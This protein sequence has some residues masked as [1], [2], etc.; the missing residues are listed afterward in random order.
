MATLA[1]RIGSALTLLIGLSVCQAGAQQRPAVQQPDSSH[2]A[3]ARDLVRSLPDWPAWTEFVSVGPAEPSKYGSNASPDRLPHVA[4]TGFDP[5]SHRVIEAV[6]DLST[7]QVALTTVDRI[8]MTTGADFTRCD[9]AVKADPR[10]QA[11]VARRGFTDPDALI[12]DGWASGIVNDGSGRRLARG[13]TYALTD[14]IN[15][16]DRPL[17]GIICTVDLD[18]RTVIDVVDHGVRPMA[19]VNETFERLRF[20]REPLVPLTIRHDQQPFSI[21]GQRVEWQDW[22]FAYLVHPRE[23]VVLYDV[24]RRIDGEERSVAWRIGLSEMVVPYGDTS[25]AWVWRNAFDVGEYGV[26][27][28]SWSLVRGADVPEEAVLL[29][30][31]AIDR[32]GGVSVVSDV[33]GIYE[34]D[35]GMYVRHRD[36]ATQQA[37]AIRGRELVVTHTAT[38]GN[39][40][41]AISYIF[42]LDGAIRVEAR[43]SG[44]LLVKGAGQ[45]AEM[46][47]APNL[48]APF[49]QHF[50]N[51]RLDLDVDGTANSVHELDAW[52]PPAGSSENPRGNAIML[53]DFEYLHESEARSE[54]NARASR[55][56]A[57]ANTERLGVNGKPT[58][59]MLMPGGN[60]FPYLDSMALPRRRARFIDHHFWATVYRNDELYAA[61]PYPNQS[62]GGEGLP[63]YIADNA[64]LHGRDVVVWYTM[65]ITHI[66]RPEDWP[67]MP[68]HVVGFTLMPMNISTAQR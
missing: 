26:G 2:I 21:S 64:P 5:A 17:E 63:H 27:V 49:H 33:V 67:I 11:A 16:Y 45:D 8:P 38:V 32:S 6:V 22:S 10:W 62:G 41:Y 68:A 48:E 23:G 54:V 42:G 9:S 24:R 19:P 51:F 28:C 3:A 4:L 20:T 46:P 66:T 65:G 30:V 34:R 13:I 52:S 60:A 29:P 50:F 55:S 37:I 1:E 43:L 47:I 57:V 36:P 40:D 25:A 12:V 53:D 44:I 7:S 58:A 14:S 61:G 35:A 15:Q 18:S 39:Y 56:W 31:P 59:Y